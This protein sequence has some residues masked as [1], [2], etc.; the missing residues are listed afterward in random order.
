MHSGGVLERRIN[1]LISWEDRWKLKTPRPDTSGGYDRSLVGLSGP[2][3]TND[4][5]H[6]IASYTHRKDEQDTEIKGFSALYTWAMSRQLRFDV[7]S[8]QYDVEGD[9]EVAHSL[10][11]EGFQQGNV[12]GC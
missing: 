6:H 11:L 3:V 2:A 1:V 12:L 8:Q 7:L 10:C 5:P 4:I 9:H